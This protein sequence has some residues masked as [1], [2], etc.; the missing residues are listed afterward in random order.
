MVFPS[1]GYSRTYIR[2]DIQFMAHLLV[3]LPLNRYIADLSDLRSQTG[4]V[5]LE[6]ADKYGIRNQTS[7]KLTLCSGSIVR[8]GPNEVYYSSSSAYRAIYAQMPSLIKGPYYN[9]F[10]SIEG[11]GNLFTE[12]SRDQ[13]HLYKSTFSSL[14]SRRNIAKMEDMIQSKCHVLRGHLIAKSD[15]GENVDI[16]AAVRSLATDVISIISILSS[17]S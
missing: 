6:L 11:V 7:F 14:F 10:N 9:Q 8:I 2:A 17:S 15:V 4:N 13:H 1:A 12:Q 5:L 16:L 3:S